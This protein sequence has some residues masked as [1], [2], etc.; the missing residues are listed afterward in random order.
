MTFLFCLGLTVVIAE[1]VNRLNEQRIKAA[2]ID[3]ATP[4]FNSVIDKMNRYRYGLLEARTAVLASGG[5]S[6]NTQGYHRYGATLD[7]ANNFP[8][9]RGFGFVRRVPREALAAYLD[10]TH[11]DNRPD[12]TVTSLG[13][14]QDELY[15]VEYLEP[16]QGST[17]SSV[18]GLDLA[19]NPFRKHAADEAML[20]GKATITSPL[21]LKFGL[22]TIFN[23]FLLFMPIYRDG[24]MPDNESARRQKAFGWAYA[25][26]NMAEV[27]KNE[28]FSDGRV[29]LRLSDVTELGDPMVFYRSAEQEGLYP[30]HHDVN[31]LGRIWRFSLSV[32][33]DYLD[34]LNLFSMTGVFILGVGISVVMSV[35]ANTLRLRRADRKQLQQERSKLEMIVESSPDGIIGK[36]TQGIIISWNSGAERL[37]GY[38]RDEVIGLPLAELIIPERLKSEEPDILRRVCAGETISA[39]ETV[40]HRKDGSEFMVSATISPIRAPDGRVIGVSKTVR[41]IS[42]QKEAERRIYNLNTELERQVRQRTAELAEVNLLFRTVLSAAHEFCIIATDLHGV[43]TFFNKGAV[44]MLGYS[45]EEVVGKATPAIFHD[46]QELASR[47]HELTLTYGETIRGFEVFSYKALQNQAEH[48]EWTYV[49]KDGGR[50]PVN[51]V[52]TAMRDERDQLMG[53]LGVA[54]DITQQRQAQEALEKAKRQADAANEAKSMFLANMSHEIRTPMNAV[55]GMLQVL[56]RNNLTPRQHEF[57]SKAH[58]AATSL[59]GLL[60]DILDY[61]K[62]D[63][64]KLEL[65]PQPFDLNALM[66]HLAIMLSGNLRDKSIELLFDLDPLLS[67]Y[68]IGDELRLQQVLINLISNAIKFTERGEVIVKTELLASDDA[69]QHIRISV[70]DSGI[71]ISPEQQTRIFGEFTQAEASTTRRYGGTGLGLVICKRLVEKMGG[72]LGVDSELGQGST[73]SLTLSFPRDT[74]LTWVPPTLSGTPLRI[75]VVDD[76]RT[77]GALLV[78]MLASLQ[79]S[80][81]DV[82]NAAQAMETLEQAS[83]QGSPFDIVLIDKQMPDMDGITLAH[84]IR[85]GLILSSRPS[86]ILLSSASNEDMLESGVSSDVERVLAKPVLI[87]PLF[88][89][90]TSANSVPVVSEPAVVPSDRSDSILKGLSVLLVEDNAFNQEVARELLIGEGV[91]VTVASGGEEGV[92]LIT[93]GTR[94]FD[95]VLMDLQMPDIDGFEATRRIRAWPAGVSLPI[96]AMTANVSPSDKQACLAAGMNGHLGKPFDFAEVIRTLAPFAGREITE[97]NPSPAENDP[98][99]R[100]LQRFGGNRTL[101]VKLLHAF[102]PSFNTLSHTLSLQCAEQNWSGGMATL[103]TLKGLVGTVGLDALYQRLASTE[104]ALKRADESEKNDLFHQLIA[105]LETDAH[106]EYEA[107]T[108]R[109]AEISAADA[110]SADSQ[111]ADIPALLVSL[112]ELLGSGNLK[113]I[114]LAEQLSGALAHEAQLQAPLRQLVHATE[115]LEFDDANRILALIKE[116]PDVEKYA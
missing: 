80:A 64:G 42:L 77:S 58:M 97:A 115:N 99:V 1:A 93:E 22:D 3:S 47:S 65:D 109:L 92:R 25:P 37:F 63:A 7:L 38:M 89:A 41:D 104:S 44:Q 114:V 110:P 27:L 98:L 40:R 32:T 88:Q 13:D 50:F 39:F 116:H 95:V 102:M 112:A 51:L 113:A 71:G 78:R 62:I 18:I 81:V 46:I 69:V 24:V 94:H 49:R 74:S 53:Y 17:N 101:L 21:S 91:N 57:A 4:L 79:V 73:F 66:Q 103:H 8:G 20:S 107:L 30:Y 14:E 105:T 2:I 12:F 33:P 26:I 48:H 19:S 28:S 75:L 67:P 87:M 16:S 76:N 108:T 34:M 100:A 31:V 68:L 60:N 85:H 36:D 84:H 43:I 86:L 96:I 72:E 70:Q 61:S 55:L 10:K 9:A 106:R 82:E 52:V 6:I 111:P 35:L 45:E 23:S 11:R 83:A 54:A 5:E 90:L 56:L 59:L 15:V 29:I